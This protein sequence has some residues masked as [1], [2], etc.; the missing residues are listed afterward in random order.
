LQVRKLI[1]TFPIYDLNNEEMIYFNNL[2]ATQNGD[3]MIEFIKN[4]NGQGERKLRY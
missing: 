1:S 2:V 3:K 4:K